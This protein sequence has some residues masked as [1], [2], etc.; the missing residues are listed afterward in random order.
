MNPR[1]NRV[2]LGDFTFVGY[3]LG[4]EETVIGVPELN[5]CFDIGRAPSEVLNIDNVLLTHGHMDH[6]AGIAYYFSQRN[7]LDNPNGTIVVPKPLEAPI[8][9][10][11]KAWIDIEGHRTPYRVV[12]LEPGEEYPIRRNLIAKTFQTEHGGA[13][14][15]YSVVEI[16]HKLKDEYVGLAGPKLAELR[17]AGT[18]LTY[19]IEIPLVCYCGDTSYGDFFELPC[20][21]EARVLILECT[22]IAENHRDRALAGS[23]LHIDHFEQLQDKLANEHILLVH[24]SRRTPLGAARAELRE[25]LSPEH[26]S[27]I[28]FLM[29]RP[30]RLEPP[31]PAAGSKA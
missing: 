26:F 9:V 17:R 3:S 16:R 10:L 12:G 21:R 2:Q 8:H 27:R 30:R 28:S 23:H 18:K 4:G 5:V 19:D 6:A 13:C 22:F 29:S 7:F 1:V 24:L 25:R 11:M 31:Q 14:L 20:V 15:G